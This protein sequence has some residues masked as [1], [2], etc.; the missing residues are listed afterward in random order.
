M[1]HL[2]FNPFATGEWVANYDGIKNLVVA[3]MYAPAGWPQ[4]AAVL[5]DVY[6]GNA[7]SLGKFVDAVTTGVY[8]TSTLHA[9]PAIKCSDKKLRTET[10]EEYM[11]N[12]QDK[13]DMTD[14]Y[15]DVYIAF[16]TN[17]AQWKFQAKEIYDGD[18]QVKT[19]NPVLFA[20]NTF[21]P[22]TPLVSAKNMSSGF[23]GSAVLQHNGYGH[24]I[25]AQ[26]SACTI[27][28]VQQFFADGS[29]PDPDTVCEPDIPLFSNKTLE[30]VIE[31][32]G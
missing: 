27:K 1:Y 26:H 5:A 20:G 17:C 30:D 28:A 4:M 18:F 24:G 11:P 23:E 21:D 14:I 22:L 13:Y 3:N 10:L 32:L 7:T 12:V 25:A 31:L 16:D 6:N 29:L 2:K 9:G 19:K 15:G 8:E